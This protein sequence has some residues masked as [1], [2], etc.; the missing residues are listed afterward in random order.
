MIVLPFCNVPR[1]LSRH[2]LPVPTPDTKRVPS[3][4]GAANSTATPTKPQTAVTSAANNAKRRLRCFCCFVDRGRRLAEP[5]S[6]LF[7]EDDFFVG[8]FVFRLCL[9]QL[10]SSIK[11]VE[12]KYNY[13]LNMLLTF[14]GSLPGIGAKVTIL[15]HV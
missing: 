2:W 5:D 8:I 15:G 3:F 6:V 11:V 10:L 13:I 4:A 14:T 12:K 1:E 7:F 9:S